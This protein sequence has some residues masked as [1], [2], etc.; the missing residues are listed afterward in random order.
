MTKPNLILGLS[1]IFLFLSIFLMFLDNTALVFLSFCIGIGLLVFSIQERK[2]LY[3][4]NSEANLKK[5]DYLL[6][7]HNLIKSQFYVNY[8]QTNGIVLDEQ[9]KLLCLIKKKDDDYS[10]LK[11]SFDQILE[12]EIIEDGNSVIKTSRG[13]QIG[14]ALIGGALAGGVG[15]IVGG[16]SGSKT[17]F[18]E[19]KKI[20]LRITL[21]DLNNP[22]QTIN[23]MNT[24]MALKKDNP[25]YKEVYEKALHWHKLM[26][27]V[28]KKQE[29]IV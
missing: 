9:N 10:L 5:I 24:E 23:F 14:G 3:K 26:S 12:S 7:Q 6:Q 27:V 4:E 21:N 8:Y 13:S 18:K 11:Y 2:K 1:I 22:V 29:N 20:D 25:Y 16:L 19:V 15:A 28:I 17:S